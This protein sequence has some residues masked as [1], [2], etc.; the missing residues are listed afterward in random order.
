M[1]RRRLTLLLLALTL[2][3]TAF[4]QEAG[5]HFDP[6]QLPRAWRLVQSV[7]VPTTQLDVFSQKLGGTVEAI[8]N[9]VLDVRGIPL[10]LNLVRCASERDAKAVHK[11]ML[12]FGKTLETCQRE[13]R[14][15]IEFVA[16]VLIPPQLRK[17]LRSIV[18]VV[19]APV[20]WTV[21]LE[22]AP[23]EQSNDAAWNDL[24]NQ[25]LL[26]SKDA[27]DERVKAKI[28]AL[29]GTFTFGKTLW[30]A[31][32]T[33]PWGTASYTCTPA[34]TDERQEG[35]ALRLQFATLPRSLKIPLV[36]VHAEIPVQAFAACMPEA[37]IDR[38]A[39]LC[40]TDRWP[41]HAKPV[42]EAL[43]LATRGAK[44]RAETV[45]AI[46]G[47]VHSSIRYEG[48]VGSRWGTLKVLKRGLG[49]CWDKAD[50]FV[51]LCRAAEIPARMVFGWLVGTS[52]HVWAQV[53]LDGEGWVSVDA[54]ASW[55][56]VSEDYV[57]LFISEGGEV[58]A[59]Y[60]SPPAIRR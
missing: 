54:T 10:Q 30:V 21:D 49:H 24:F 12:G 2:A 33:A 44:T 34:S 38:E 43:A 15:L 7:E 29:R 31:R 53:Y 42:T 40:A 16:Q 51:T 11:A 46:L 52:G 57:P 39:L 47:W 14:Y 18:G 58:P 60:W 9:H 25:L 8:S 37:R 28:D 27:S 59:V 3:P 26:Y 23:L 35:D 17:K 6:D 1:L 5:P 50:V 55:T 19:S 13:G 48:K 56:G 32:P 20:T 41:T 22:L 4:A 45:E 36:K